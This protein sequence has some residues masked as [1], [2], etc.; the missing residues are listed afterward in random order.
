[1][2]ERTEELKRDIEDTRDRM[3]GTLDEIGDRV[4]PGRIVERRVNRVKDTTNRLTSS[5]M[6]K[7][8]AAADRTR[9]AVGNLSSSTSGATSSAAG[10]LT[11]A[12]SSAADAVTGAPQKMQ[13]AAQGNPM[14]V[15]GVAFAIGLLA[16]SLTPSSQEE[17]DLVEHV[18]EPLKQELSDVG[19]NVADSVKGQVQ[20]GVEST[21]YVAAV[22]A[23]EV[24][25]HATDAAGEVSSQAKDAKDQVQS[26]AKSAAKDVK[27]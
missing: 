2:V 22:A 12:T 11:G 27:Q 3:S 19:H 24:K 8:R 23:D 1:M 16:G 26:D 4:S 18:M 15:G 9:G 7:P 25:Q 17:Q 10:A 14:I 13:E 21:K 20:E 5:V 6:G